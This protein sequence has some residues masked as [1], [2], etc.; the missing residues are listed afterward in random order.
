M[1]INIYLANYNQ[2]KIFVVWDCD[3]SHVSCQLNLGMEAV[4]DKAQSRFSST[5][6]NGLGWVG[7]FRPASSL[8]TQQNKLSHNCLLQDPLHLSC[9]CFYLVFCG[10]VTCLGV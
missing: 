10:L 2:D 8:M 1:F 3:I 6:M 9:V 5:F 4:A 7:S